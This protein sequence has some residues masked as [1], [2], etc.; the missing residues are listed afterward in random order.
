M[1]HPMRRNDREITDPAEI[2]GILEKALF[3]HLGVCDGDEPYV[4]PVN[5]GV[6]EGA[7]YFHCAPEGRKLDVLRRNPKACFQVE[8]DTELV[9]STRAC[10][11][12]MLYRSVV[13]SGVV[14]VVESLEEKARG[15]TA[16]MKKCAGDAF[17]HEFTEQ[18]LGAVVVLRL[19]PVSRT[20]K[21]RRPA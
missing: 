3:G 12:G 16:L 21:A 11:W 5:F 7:I 14:S 4:L 10:G 13:V 8:T 9:T 18:E 20:G 17:S 1:G 6:S 19:E 15:L 2:D